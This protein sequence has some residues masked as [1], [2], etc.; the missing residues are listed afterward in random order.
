MKTKLLIALIVVAAITIALAGWAVQ[1]VRWTLTSGW[2]S[3][4]ARLA[5]A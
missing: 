5:T 4:R 1:G 3:R 2:S